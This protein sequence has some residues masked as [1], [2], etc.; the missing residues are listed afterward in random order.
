M[1]YILGLIFFFSSFYVALSA[2]GLQSSA[3][4]QNADLGYTYIMGRIDN[5]LYVLSRKATRFRGNYYITAFDALGLGQIWQRETSL[6]KQVEQVL[7]V[8]AKDD[9]LHLVVHEYEQGKS[10]IRYLKY[11]TEGKIIYTKSIFTIE[12]K[13]GFVAQQQVH[14]SEDFSKIGIANNWS[15]NKNW[16]GVY[17][18]A[19]DQKLWSS[20][21][22]II[23]DKDENVDINSL[24]VANNGDAFLLLSDRFSEHYIYHIPAQDG[25]PLVY[26]LG[27]K[28]LPIS[29]IK[30][31]FNNEQ[32]SLHLGFFFEQ[33]GDYAYA[34]Q[35]LR[36]DKNGLLFK[37][38]QV[39][40]PEFLQQ[41]AKKKNQAKKG[42]YALEI[43]DIYFHGAEVLLVGEQFRRISRSSNMNPADDP[44]YFS[45]YDYFRNRVGQSTTA[46]EYWYGALTIFKYKNEALTLQQAIVKD[47]SS[48]DDDGLLG[49][50]VMANEDGNYSFIYNN[51]YRNQG[52]MEVFT[53]GKDEKINNT[54]LPFPKNIKD[55]S[56]QW[57]S[58]F[59]AKA[60]YI[61]A[62]NTSDLFLLKLNL[63]KAIEYVEEE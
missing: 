21:S 45:R 20:E 38:K 60:I 31:A 10:D 44:F 46:F 40:Q 17:D 1:K 48:F 14:L 53:L 25:A 13:G 42:I 28:D 29:N 41:I 35:Y 11:D 23:I 63:N 61:L 56:N 50:F 19:N 12:G 51:S 55:I 62:V 34:L 9:V 26:T 7:K 37:D 18:L 52:Q 36:L 30:A 39:F 27:V 33:R 4:I 8:W 5:R 15:K 2:Q 57:S 24:N 6:G 43:K 49:S 58:Y 16:L 32:E 47:Q 54:I 3:S 59:S 22:K